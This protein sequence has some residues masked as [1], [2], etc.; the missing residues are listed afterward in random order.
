[1]HHALII[2]DH[3]TMAQTIKTELSTAGWGNNSIDV[4]AMIKHGKQK[5]ADNKCVLLVVDREFR[6]RFGSV[7]AEMSAIIANISQHTPLYLIFE[8]D[9]TQSFDAWLPH[10]AGVFKLALQPHNLCAAIAEI[11]RKHIESVPTSA[12]CSPMAAGF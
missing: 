11:N 9:Y 3:Q 10:T 8:H 6:R 5:A 4:A 7:I 12:Y 2:S 1:M